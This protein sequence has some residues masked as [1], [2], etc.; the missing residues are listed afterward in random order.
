[1]EENE[2]GIFLLIWKIKYK[3]LGKMVIIL[4]KYNLPT[5]YMYVCI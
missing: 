4:G 1:M 2:K 5:I 3:N